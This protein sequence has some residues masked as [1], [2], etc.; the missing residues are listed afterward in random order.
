MS[1]TDDTNAARRGSECNDLLGPPPVGA[2]TVGEEALLRTWA[3]RYATKK[4]AAERE[5]YSDLMLAVEWL[6]NDGHM[7]QEHL[8][9]LR[10]AYER[11]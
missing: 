10:A 5:R 1:T 9:R 7:N 8:A 3:D 6:I 4:V 2:L 11:A